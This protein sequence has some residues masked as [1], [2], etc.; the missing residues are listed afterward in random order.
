MILTRWLQD[1]TAFAC[2]NVANLSGLY[3]ETMF[4]YSSDEISC[5]QIM[6][7]YF[8][9]TYLFSQAE[10]QPKIFEDFKYTERGKYEQ[11]GRV[12]KYKLLSL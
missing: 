9:V 10:V 3:S 4:F 5:R 11:Y 7:I 6:P 2:K 12:I 8:S 1:Y